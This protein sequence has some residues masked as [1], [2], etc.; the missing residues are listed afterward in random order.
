MQ[1]KK[2]TAAMRVKCKFIVNQIA[3]GNY[4]PRLKSI[5]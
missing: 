3:C 4:K 5:C 1:Y 2:D